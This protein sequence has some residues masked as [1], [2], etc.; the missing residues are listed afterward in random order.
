[1]E[2][3][4]RNAPELCLLCAP[5]TAPGTSATLNAI[6]A[7]TI[8]NFIG[9]LNR[10]LPEPSGTSSTICARTVRKLVCFLPLCDRAFH[11][12]CLLSAPEPSEPHQPAGTLRNFVSYLR[13][14]PPQFHQP[15]APQPWAALSSICTVSFRNLVSHL[16]W[17]PPEPHQQSAPKPSGTSSA[18]EPSG[19]LR[20]QEPSGTSSAICSL[21]NLISHCTGTLRILISFLPRNPP[22][23]HQPSAPEGSGTLRNL[24]RNL[25]LQLCRIA[26]KLFWAQDPISTFAVVEISLRE[27]RS[28]DE[29]YEISSYL[30]CLF[31]C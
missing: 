23:P 3:V 25:V 24:L 6:S 26:P 4:C 15:S 29:R 17:N 9:H 30:F 1:M 14:N 21:R 22:E 27:Y 28:I 18:P 2:D 12:P 13:W 7:G 19:T 11:Q 20:A 16:Q 5:D 31:C 8:R 10:N